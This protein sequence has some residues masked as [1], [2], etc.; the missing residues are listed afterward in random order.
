MEAE[1]DLEPPQ[2]DGPQHVKCTSTKKNGERCGAWA[3]RGTDMCAGHLRLG[4]AEDPAGY[5]DKGRAT[6]QRQAKERKKSLLDHMQAEVERRSEDIVG[7]LLRAGLDRGEWR[8]LV[9]L[10]ERV[11]GRPTERVET[12]TADVDLDQLTPEQRAQLRAGLYEAFPQLR[13]AG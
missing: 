6:R 13:E 3:V 5:G 1:R 7:A 4:I 2:L 10:L 8:A 9:A 11:Y 12:S